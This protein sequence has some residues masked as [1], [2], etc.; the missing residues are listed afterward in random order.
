MSL[1]ARSIHEPTVEGNGLH[2]REE[3]ASYTLP[4]APTTPPNLAVRDVSAIYGHV[5]VTAVV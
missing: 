5:R 4:R 3:A 1:L 2:G